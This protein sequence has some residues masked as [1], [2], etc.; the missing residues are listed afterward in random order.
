MA[1]KTMHL[2]LAF[3]IRSIITFKVPLDLHHLT[4]NQSGRAKIFSGGSQ[5]LLFILEYIFNSTF[6]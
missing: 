1:R 4:E 5:R 3:E 2:S 6:G